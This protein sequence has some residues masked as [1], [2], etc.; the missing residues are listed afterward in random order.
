MI[1]N[2]SSYPNIGDYDLNI[3]SGDF[4][5]RITIIRKIVTLISKYKFDIILIMYKYGLTYKCNL[6]LMQ[7]SVVIFYQILFMVLVY[8]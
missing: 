1:S 7:N 3:N 2:C 4:L 5:I 6:I 8:Y